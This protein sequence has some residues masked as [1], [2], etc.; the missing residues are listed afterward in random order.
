MLTESLTKRRVSL[1]NEARDRFG[2]Q[3][4]WS[5]DGEILTSKDGKTY[6]VRDL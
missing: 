5:S 4:V 6:N 1:L 3:N 2:K